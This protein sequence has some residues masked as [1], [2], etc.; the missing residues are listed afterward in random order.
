[1]N[2]RNDKLVSSDYRKLL[3]VIGK[4]INLKNV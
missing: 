2:M 1:M 4:T 3:L